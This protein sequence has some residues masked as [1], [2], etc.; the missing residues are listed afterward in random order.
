MSTT[1]NTAPA[2]LTDERINELHAASEVYE[3]HPGAVLEFARDIERELRAA[4]AQQQP[5]ASGAQPD[6][7]SAFEDWAI[8][9]G[10]AFRDEK[11]GIYSPAGGLAHA[12]EAWQA[13][14]ALAAAPAAAQP[15][16]PVSDGLPEPGEDVLVCSDDPLFAGLRIVVRRIVDADRERWLLDTGIHHREV[17]N[18]TAW[19]KLPPEFGA[20]AP[21]GEQQPQGGA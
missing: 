8:R 2:L 14:A 10:F 17:R 13:R 15:W 5:A 4:L 19:M 16:T 3:Y 7:R 12:W 1:T 20:A 6:E 18:V 9:A 21:A 11:H